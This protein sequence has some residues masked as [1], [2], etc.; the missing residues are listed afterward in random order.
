MAKRGTGGGTG[1]GTNTPPKADD[2][3]PA[4]ARKS[5]L[6]RRQTKISEHVRRPKP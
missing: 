2:T 6:P 5:G 1:R 4:R 3:G